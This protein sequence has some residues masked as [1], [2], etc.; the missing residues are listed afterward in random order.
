MNER[1]MMQSG[2]ESESGLGRTED[3]KESRSLEDA[4]LEPGPQ[5]EE[6]RG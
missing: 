5:I 2:E 4:T 6:K 3:N 1:D